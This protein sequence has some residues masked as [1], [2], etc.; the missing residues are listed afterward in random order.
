MFGFAWIDWIKIINYIRKNRY[1][2]YQ[3]CLLVE[4][5]DKHHCKY[6]IITI[7]FITSD[8]LML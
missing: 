6:L 8:F 5:S 1:F 2:L 3:D 7:K 4:N